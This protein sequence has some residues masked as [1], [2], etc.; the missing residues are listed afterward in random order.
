[1]P[2]LSRAD[3]A[4]LAASNKALAK[5][6]KR[7][8]SRAAAGFDRDFHALLVERSGN[9]EIARLLASLLPRIQRLELA[10]FGDQPMAQQS[11]A[12]HDEIVAALQRGDAAAACAAMQR[13]WE[14][15]HFPSTPSAPKEQPCAPPSS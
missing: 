1:L 13:N 11:L 4:R 10:F 7:G 9:A 5:A 3:L 6:L 15:Q 14:W 12:D 8:D 2:H